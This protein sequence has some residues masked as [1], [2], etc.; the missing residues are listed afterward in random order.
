MTVKNLS[1]NMRE[2]IIDLRPRQSKTKFHPP[3]LIETEQEGRTELIILHKRNK[4][5]RGK[6]KMKN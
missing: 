5:G 2:R 3:S 4:K 1:V 6:E